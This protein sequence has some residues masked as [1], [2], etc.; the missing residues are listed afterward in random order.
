MDY[1]ALFAIF[2]RSFLFTVATL[3]PIINPLAAAP[4]F[5]S[6]TSGVS[7]TSRKKLSER[8]GINLFIMLTVA[9]FSGNMVLSF[10]GIS[11]PI[12]RIGGGLLVIATAWK[13]VNATGSDTEEAIDRAEGYSIDRLRAKAFYPLTFPIICGPGT[14]AATLTVGATLSDPSTL[15]SMTKLSAAILALL[16]VSVITYVCLRFAAPFLTRLGTNGTAILM[17][18]SAFI[19]LC[20]GVQIAWDGLSEITLELLVEAAQRSAEFIP[21]S[22]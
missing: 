17:R 15:V 1:A 12:I 3:L 16:T 20:L 11:L 2:S 14:I 6:L 21:T 10:F 9:I 13:L 8:I 19:L 5:L 18:L 4:I 7:P 22:K